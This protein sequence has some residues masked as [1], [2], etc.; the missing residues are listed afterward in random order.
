M[1]E[2]SGL[3]CP[4]HYSAAVYVIRFFG[5]VILTTCIIKQ[6]GHCIVTWYAMSLSLVKL[7]EIGTS[8]GR[9]TTVT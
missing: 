9:D 4:L 1:H 2:V 5:T 8:W 6:F 3:A 7:T